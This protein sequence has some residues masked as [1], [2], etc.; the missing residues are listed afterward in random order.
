MR[1]EKKR[2]EIGTNQRKYTSMCKW[3]VSCCQNQGKDSA[4]IKIKK[5]KQHFFSLAAEKWHESVGDSWQHLSAW[6][7]LPPL[8]CWQNGWFQSGRIQRDV[9][10]GGYLSPLCWGWSL[11]LDWFLLHYLPSSSPPSFLPSFFFFLPSYLPSLFILFMSPQSW[12][13]FI[14][15]KKRK[16]DPGCDVKVTDV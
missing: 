12:L 6:F 9:V 11:M 4:T 10:Y 15:K 14:F 13:C 8:S 5:A 16:K 2:K 3:E 7:L 1:K